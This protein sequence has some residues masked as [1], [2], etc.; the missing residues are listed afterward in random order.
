MRLPI[1]D[2]AMIDDGHDAALFGRDGSIACLCLPRF[3][4]GKKGERP[5]AVAA[6]P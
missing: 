2:Y 3:D 6:A 1:E 4:S 5:A